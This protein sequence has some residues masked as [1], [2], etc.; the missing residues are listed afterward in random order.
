MRIQY[1]LLCFS[2]FFAIAGFCADAL[3]QDFSR[4]KKLKQL[5]E[6]NVTAFIE[7]TS[8]LNS[9]QNLDRDNKQIADYLDRH[10]DKKARFRSNMVFIMPGLPEQ[11]KTLT[12]AKEDYIDQVQT[13][14]A[15]I[16][17]YYSEIDISNVDL[18]KNKK[19]ASVNTVMSESG[20][21]EVIDETG[22]SE[23]IPFEG[24]SEC[25][26]VLKLSKKGYIQ[27]YSANC[28]TTMTFLEN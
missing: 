5:S 2:T 25:F 28:N 19:T 7:K 22:S 20:I 18:S 9:H 15:E 27:M 8:A 3:A 13:G 21:M 4:S 24:Q 14:A 26:Q 1:A 12:L 11:Q 10:I 17:H 6:T 23:S 16:E